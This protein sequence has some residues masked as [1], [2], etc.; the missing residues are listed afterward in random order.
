MTITDNGPLFSSNIEIRADVDQS[1]GVNST[2]AFLTLRNSLGLTMSSTNWQASSTTGDVNCDSNANST[3]A[4]LILRESL[5]LGMSGT[6]W[7]V[8]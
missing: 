3:D 1:G 2:D 6:G 8:N 7:C 4:L 5:G